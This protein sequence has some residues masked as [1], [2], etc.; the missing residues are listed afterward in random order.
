MRA[1]ILANG[2]YG[3][4]SFCKNLE[5]YELIICADNGVKHARHLG[6]VPHYILGDLDSA[7]TENIAY[8]EG[9][10]C[11]LKYPAEKDETDTELA[12][13]K[14]IALGATQ[15]D[16]Y[17]AIGTRLDHTLGNVH[18]LYKALKKHVYVCMM[19]HHNEV[20]LMKDVITLKGARGDLVSLIPFSEVVK[21]VTTTNLAYALDQGTFK[22]GEPY[23]VSN[24]MLGNEASIS[25]AE[26]LLLVIKAN[27]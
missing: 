6:I 17:G 5:D 11:I 22:M 1:L 25:I 20:H 12:I 3:D 23:G 15:I 10:S 7:S 13:D 26:G 24:Y 16:V 4:Y 14:A 2:D 8:Y 18:L 9:R 27:D 21:G 19:N